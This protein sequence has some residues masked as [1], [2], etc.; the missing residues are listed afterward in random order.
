MNSPACPNCGVSIPLQGADEEWC[1]ACGK[2]LPLGVVAAVHAAAK[3]LRKA[4]AAAEEQAD[5]ASPEAP[6]S[7][8]GPTS[9]K[10][11][12]RLPGC[13]IYLFAAAMILGAFG[14]FTVT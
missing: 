3:R 1:E 4:Q 10:A 2:K 11:A 5:A 14:W 6:I 7:P 9:V 13:S 8:A 12:K